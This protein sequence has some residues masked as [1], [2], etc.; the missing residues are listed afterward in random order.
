MAVEIKGTLPHYYGDVEKAW[1]PKVTTVEW[2]DTPRFEGY[3]S[4]I[5]AMKVYPETMVP[6]WELLDVTGVEECVVYAP[7]YFQE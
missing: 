3:M 2:A 6:D 4:V 5:D 7:S 1:F